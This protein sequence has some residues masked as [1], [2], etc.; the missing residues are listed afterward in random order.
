MLTPVTFEQERQAQAFAHIARTVAR[1]AHKDQLD[2]GG[3]LYIEHAQYVGRFENYHTAKVVGLL[4]D[5]LEVDGWSI[6]RLTDYGFPEFI[7]ERLLLL[8]RPEGM[9][10][11]EYIQ[12]LAVDEICRLV[13]IRDLRHNMRPERLIRFDDA[14]VARIKKYHRW[15]LFLKSYVPE[16]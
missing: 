1:L 16:K 6:K 5:V 2:L 10:Y 14:A 15:Y 9:S 7:L 3:N 12:R 8:Y 11:S 13:K 4:H